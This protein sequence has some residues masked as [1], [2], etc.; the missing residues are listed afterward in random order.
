MG[1]LSIISPTGSQ[2]LNWDP[3]DEAQ[4]RHVREQFDEHLDQGYSA[5]HLCDTGGEGKKIVA[6]DAAAGKIVM[7]PKLGG[8]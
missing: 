4:T 5:Y 8:G 7:V 2:K 3:E 6:F 1:E